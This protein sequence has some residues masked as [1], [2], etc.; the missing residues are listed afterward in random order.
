M[1]HR[2]VGDT[3]WVDIYWRM[4]G[5]PDGSWGGLN[6]EAVVNNDEIQICT[7][8]ASSRLEIIYHHHIVSAAHPHSDHTSP[9]ASAIPLA[10]DGRIIELDAILKDGRYSI[11]ADGILAAME[12]HRSL[13]RMLT[14]IES[15]YIF[16]M[17][18][19]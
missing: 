6:Q 8:A 5:K 18:F 1:E 7:I 17:G 2:L 19:S 13:T 9:T 16:R 10:S 14:A 12:Y 3:T 15:R 11:F 4:Y